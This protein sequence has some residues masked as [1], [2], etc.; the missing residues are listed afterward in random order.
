MSH[1]RVFFSFN[2]LRF[3]I[4]Y[5]FISFPLSMISAGFIEIVQLL[6]NSASGTECV[7]RMLETVDAEGDTVSTTCP[8][9]VSIVSLAD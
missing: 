3:V 7:K 2:G 8:I 6:I 4:P 1:A 9:G 5:L